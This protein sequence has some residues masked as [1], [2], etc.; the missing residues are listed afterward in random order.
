MNH[1]LVETHIF[2]FVVGRAFVTDIEK[3]KISSKTRSLDVGKVLRYFSEVTKVMRV[4][5]IVVLL[6][7]FSHDLLYEVIFMCAFLQDG[8]CPGSNLLTAV[9]VLLS[10]VCFHTLNELSLWG[11]SRKMSCTINYSTLKYSC[12]LLS[13]ISFIL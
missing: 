13:V 4:D 10:G 3:L 1:R 8:I 6:Y 2:S 7:F 12:Y 5:L 9:E 11:C